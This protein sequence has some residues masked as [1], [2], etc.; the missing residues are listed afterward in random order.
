MEYATE[1]ILSFKGWC[2][3]CCGDTAQGTRVSCVVRDWRGL[4]APP[5]DSEWL[6]AIA[7][8]ERRLDNCLRVQD[9]VQSA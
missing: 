5:I 2:F 7:L 1:G 9:Q 3:Y 8:Q 6:F 4:K